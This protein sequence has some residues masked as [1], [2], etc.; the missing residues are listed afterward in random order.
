ME[1]EAHD[2]I[3]ELPEHRQRIH[4][5]KMEDNHFRRLFDDYHE[6]NKE[7]HRIE[8][9]VENHADDYTENLKKKR[10]TLKDQLLQ[11]ILA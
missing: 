6:T 7:I 10:L 4:E 11:T 5:L 9:G 2:L 8:Q 3:H 1:N